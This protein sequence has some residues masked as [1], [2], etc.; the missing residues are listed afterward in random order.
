MIHE[1]Q[2]ERHCGSSRGD[3]FKQMEYDSP[4]KCCM[5]NSATVSATVSVYSTW[6]ENAPPGLYGAFEK[7]LH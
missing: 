5:V 2:Q 3:I 4:K 7:E 1:R 6:Q